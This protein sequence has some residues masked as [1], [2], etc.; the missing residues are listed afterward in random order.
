M[1][2]KV[3][4]VAS[5]G[6]HWIQL[7]RITPAF[8]DCSVRYLTT[9]GDYRETVSAP[10]YVV[11]DANKTKKFLFFLMFIQV[12]F[13]LLRFR[14]DFVVSTGA[15]PG[16]AA[17]VLGKLFGAKTLW[18]DSVANSEQLSES[19]RLVRH[20]SDVWLTQWPGLSSDAGPNYWGRVL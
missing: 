14:P 13:C 19:G 4:A 8:S 15:A 9:S 20:F 12:G 16:F 18:L 17:I 2:K 6:G 5:P 3:L 1:R 7:M 11:S 10:L